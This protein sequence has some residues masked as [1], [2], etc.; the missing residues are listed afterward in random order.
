M[1]TLR[2]A[3]KACYISVFA[4]LL[5]ICAVPDTAFASTTAYESLSVGSTR[6]LY[7][8][9]PEKG[10]TKAMWT[11]NDP[12]SVDIISQNAA[13]CTIKANAVTS[14]LVI[15]QCVYNYPVAN[16]IFTYIG[17][18]FKDFYVTVTESSGGSTGGSGSYK[19]SA[20]TSVMNLDMA[21]GSKQM[22]ITSGMPLSTELYIRED[23]YRGSCVSVGSYEAE[24]CQQEFVFFPDAIGT[25]TVKFELIQKK[26]STQSSIRSS[27]MVKANVTCSHR[28]NQGTVTKQPTD[29][30]TGIRTYTCQACKKTKTEVIP[31]AERTIPDCTITLDEN[32][33][34][35]DSQPKEPS[36]HVAYGS[37]VLQEGTD[38]TLC[39]TDNRDAG[40]GTVEVTGIGSY[41]G[42]AKKTFS[43]RKASQT[44]AV[45]VAADTVR[46][47]ETVQVTAEGIGDFTYSSGNGAV[48]AVSPSGMVTG[49]AE[50][51]AEIHV[52]ASGDK[53]YQ[54]AN[55]SIRI[56]VMASAPMAVSA[57]VSSLHLQEGRSQEIMVTVSGSLP[58]NGWSLVA[59][60]EKDG[61]F[62]TAWTGDWEGN[63]HPLTV[64]GIRAGSGKLTLY[65]KDKSTGEYLA[66]TWIN[67]SV[68][69]VKK[70]KTRI[71]TCSI[72]LGRTSYPYTGSAKRPSVIVRNGK[73][74]LQK[75]Q[76]YTVSYSTNRNA[77]KA[78]IRISGKGAYT[79]TVTRRFTIQ[80]ASQPVRVSVSCKRYKARSLQK[81][82]KS[83]TIKVRNAKGRVTYRSNTRY[84]SISHGKVKVK[85]GIPR[86][87]YKITVKAAGN[88]NYK[89]ASKTVRIE[90][91]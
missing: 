80:K 19:I 64:S 41:T 68:S 73:Q 8:N 20:S 74:T 83:F 16:G 85:K 81:K 39:Y 82:A 23:S 4:I 1:E 29:T 24:G 34:T 61:C 63:S 38:Y 52:T 37:T 58:G 27:M 35:Y 87:T 44:L 11:S 33:F 5:C 12:Q 25:Q 47:G 3:K 79:G 46:V 89:P 67:V 53:N 14:R 18:G 66:S 70:E 7:L 71:S 86:G 50:G 55:A 56:T 57:S 77:G 78:S 21:E 49:V 2:K 30:E 42:T 84:V 72:Q 40:I 48:A 26:S 45:S 90:V 17:T 88:G 10:V 28:Y 60:R 54:S 32:S 13:A 22:T 36:V 69:S 51:N 91:R 9:A 62:S 6:T 31:A 65:V 59:E 43:I 15:I 75:D 76:D